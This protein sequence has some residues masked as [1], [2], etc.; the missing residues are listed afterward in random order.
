MDIASLFPLFEPSTGVGILVVYG[1]FAFAMTYWYSRGYDDN[2][3]SFLVARRELNTFQG[4]LSV[5]A[6]WLWAPGLFISTQQAY[7]NGLV[8]LFWFCLGNFLTLGAFAYFAKKIREESPEGFTFSGYLKNRFSSR[9]QWLFVVEMMIL[10][11]C[12]FAINLLAGSKTVETLTGI[13]YTL[14]TL[15]MAGVAILYSFRTGLKAT[16][17]TEVI[18]IIVVWAGVIILVPWVISEAGGW[19]T[20][21][22]GLGGRTGEG[23]SIL[24]TPFAWGIFTGF[25]AAAFLGHM[26]GPWGDNS[27]YQRAFSIKT[28]SIIPSYVIA[29]FVF[30]VVP[31]MMGL[32]GFVAAGAGLEI[33]KAFWGTTNAITIGTF[34]PPVAS[35]IFAFMVF[36]GLVAI[37]DSQFASVANM[38]GHDL[39]NQFKEGSDD[40][41]IITY[42]RLGM[43]ALAVAGLI[44]ANIP[45]MQLVW[46]FLFFAVLRAA[47]WL[48][49]MMSLLKPDWVTE[50]GMFWGILVAA[51]P[52]EALFV[53]GK[54]F[55]GGS[56]ITFLGTLIAILG[57]PIL[58]LIFSNM[59]ASTQGEA[60]KA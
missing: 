50:P 45:G 37:L 59:S 12:A 14:A 9:L 57:A 22:A 52:G 60:I 33:P 46:L 1:L 56:G 20:V 3:T 41:D 29:S 40:K 31:I 38:T 6:A 39:F 4:S 16:V 36:A 49:S 25:G 47:V 7:V 23:A 54:M 19:S 48:P 5:A 35:I 27:F 26:G 13:N 17:V 21:V 53:W 51:I 58:T 42:A 28:G 30:I 11:T 8:G 43:V 2:K 15:L 10:A 44:I 32:L 18:K 55:G 24:G 34:L